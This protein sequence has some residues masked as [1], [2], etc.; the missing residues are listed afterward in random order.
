MSVDNVDE[1][2]SGATLV[3]PEWEFS[4]STF[5][6]TLKESHAFG[7]VQKGVEAQ[8]TIEL[9]YFGG[10]DAAANVRL[11]RCDTNNMARKCAG[12]VKAEFKVTSP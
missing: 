7:N 4:V 10:G 11:V 6:R 3:S 9:G 2:K 5:E 8:G 12:H 1:A